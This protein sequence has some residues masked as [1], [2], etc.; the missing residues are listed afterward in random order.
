MNVYSGD[1]AGDDQGTQQT[2]KKIT[3]L[4]RYRSLGTGMVHCVPTLHNTIA[5][6]RGT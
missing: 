3:A 6:G 2:A 5:V 4:K 1:W